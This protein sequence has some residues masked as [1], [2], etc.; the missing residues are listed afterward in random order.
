MDILNAKGKPLRISASS[1]ET[2]I[3]CKRKW[4][5]GY[6]WRL[7]RVSSPEAQVGSDVHDVLET[8]LSTGNKP[9][10]PNN[11]YWR[12]AEPGLKFLPEVKQ[13][14]V[15][16]DWQVEEWVKC[17]CGPL[18]FVGKVDLYNLKDFDRIQIDD[19]KTTKDGSWRWAKTPSQ[20]AKLIQ[21]HAYA[22]CIVQV[23][24]LVAPEAVDFR[25]I[26]YCTKGTP[27]AMEVRATNVPW[28][29]VEETWKRLEKI[30][31]EMVALATTITEP[32]EVEATVTSCRK[33]GGC[34]YADMCKASHHNKSN[35]APSV[36]PSVIGDPK[37][38]DRLTA[39]RAQLGLGSETAAPPKKTKPRKEVKDP[40]G[41]P[42]AL[43]DK[44]VKALEKGNDIPISAAEA[45]AKSADVHLYEALAIANIKNSGGFLAAKESPTLSDPPV[46]PLPEASP[47]NEDT[48]V[49][50]WKKYLDSHENRM[51]RAAATGIVREVTGAQRVRMQRLEAFMVEFNDTYGGLYLSGNTF[52]C[53]A[54]ELLK[55]AVDEVKQR[56]IPY[57]GLT[58]KEVEDEGM[59]IGKEQKVLYGLVVPKDY[60]G[61]AIETY[62]KF[63]PD[64]MFMVEALEGVE[65]SR[66]PPSTP[67][68]ATTLP[69]PA[70]DS[71]EEAV[72]VIGESSSESDALGDTPLGRIVKEVATPTIYIDC[73][74]EDPAGVYSFT[75]FIR[76][77]EQ[78]VEKEGGKVDDKFMQPLPYYGLIDYGKGPGRVAGKVLAALHRAGPQLFR[79][80]MYVDGKHPLADEII[81][82]LRRLKGVR[83]VRASR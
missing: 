43:A 71:E 8:Y 32:E 47:D 40:Q 10:D 26:N 7:E 78:A 6:Y 36:P 75:D 73:I 11:R 33:Y 58:S 48:V 57:C 19:H 23:H 28:S 20:L 44:L 79:G 82:I 52:L 70:K 41:D 12:I 81:P 15:S 59:V 45:M 25:H 77:F 51:S 31:E 27:K 9:E 5:Y 56:T 76:P 83:V 22:W 68:K 37:M 21:P 69:R 62:K 49:G 1:V 16:G 63:R 4:A 55:P 17:Q 30:A 24:G 53:S 72:V 3:D 80:D 46:L 2:Y 54:G 50:K 64:S 67:P 66:S 60:E 39:L 38:S 35:K 61:T 29:D 74:P 13:G 14:G 65:G 18:P 42:N 34:P